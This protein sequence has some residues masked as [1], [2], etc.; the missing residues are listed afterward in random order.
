MVAIDDKDLRTRFLNGL[1]ASGSELMIDH[2][3]IFSQVAGNNHVFDLL[4]FHPSGNLFHDSGAIG[5]ILVLSFQPFQPSLSLMPDPFH[6]EQMKVGDDHHLVRFVHYR[7]RLVWLI[8]TSW[9][10]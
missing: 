10:K 1:E 2:L 8:A 7:I 3:A 9:E 5:I 4:L 6:V